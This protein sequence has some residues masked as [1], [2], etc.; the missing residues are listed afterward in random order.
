M[1]ELLAACRFDA[2]FLAHTN[3]AGFHRPSATT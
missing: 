3:A 1:N 2:D